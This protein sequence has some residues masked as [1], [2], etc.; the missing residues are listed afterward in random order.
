MEIRESRRVDSAEIAALLK[1]KCA[2][3]YI[4]RQLAE[5]CVELAQAAL[6]VV[7]VR[8]GEASHLNESDVMDNLVEEIAD[9]SIMIDLALEIMS[10]AKIDAV[11]GW[12]DS[13]MNRMHKRL[14]A[15]PDNIETMLWG[16]LKRNESAASAPKTC[17]CGTLHEQLARME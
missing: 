4:Y 1:R 10:D 7:R 16:D 11:C 15:M 6:K 5:E 14:S 13:K 12:I 8:N 2:P 3:D 17:A 9:A